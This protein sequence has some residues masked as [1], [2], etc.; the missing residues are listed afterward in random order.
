MGQPICFAVHKYEL[1]TREK[2]GP[3]PLGATQLT[4]FLENLSRHR[5]RTDLY[6]LCGAENL[7]TQIGVHSV[8]PRFSLSLHLFDNALN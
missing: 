4:L 1:Q 2:G 5:D 6:R 7:E 8:C 3:A